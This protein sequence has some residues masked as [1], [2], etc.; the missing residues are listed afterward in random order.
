M[1]IL[2]TGA[3]GFIGAHLCERLLK[4]GHKVFGVDNIAYIDDYKRKRLLHLQQVSRQPS[5]YSSFIMIWHDLASDE[6]MESVWANTYNVFEHGFDIV[7]HL[8][9][10]TGV[11]ASK[12]KPEE[13]FRDNV[14][15]F[16]N[17]LIACHRHKI[18][19]LVYTSSSSVYGDQE[20]EMSEMET[21]TSDQVSYYA[22][23]KRAGEALAKSMSTHF[24][25]TKVICC[26]LFTVY[27]PW[28][29]KD[30]APYL[31][32]EKIMNGEEIELRDLGE[33]GIIDLARDFTYVDDIVDGLLYVTK[34]PLHGAN[35][36]TYNLG[37]GNPILIREFIG[38]LAD[39]LGKEAKIKSVPLPEGDVKQTWAST[40]KYM[41]DIDI[42]GMDTDPYEGVKKFVEWFKFYR[43][44]L[45][46]V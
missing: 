15:A 35:Y 34:A 42:N 18:P 7:Y 25:E 21:S 20:Y 13:Y 37:S 27:G 9:A 4:E 8:A 38:V 16:Q 19:K 45:F 39:L 3:L 33:D 23:T 40:A 24:L 26:R 29:R 43:K 11:Q 14:V 44:E 31:F 1:Q 10:S 41:V 32:A 36:A 6:A 5:Q 28:G 12:D 46:T 2:V 30:M 22:G 17:V